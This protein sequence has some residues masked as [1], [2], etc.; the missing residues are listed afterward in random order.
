MMERRGEGVPL[1]L[2]SS[3]RLSGKEP[4]YEI[5]DDAELR[6]TIFAAEPKRYIG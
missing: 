4:K 2:S 6:L 1:I 3:M 5:F